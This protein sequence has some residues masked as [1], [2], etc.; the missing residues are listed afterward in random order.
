MEGYAKAATIFKPLGGAMAGRFT[1]AVLVDP[2]LGAGGGKDEGGLHIPSADDHKSKR[3]EEEKKKGPEGE[4]EMRA[5]ESPKEHAARMGMYGMLTREV[6]VWVPAKLLC[7]R[8]GVKD[9]NPAPTEPEPGPPAQTQGF[10][11][12]QASSTDFSEEPGVAAAAAD[13]TTMTGTSRK[14]G[15]RDLANIGLG[16]DDDQGRDI[17]TYSRPAM[18]IFKAIF[19]SDDESGD[20]GGDGGE[21]A[22]ELDREAVPERAKP[23]G[24]AIPPEGKKGEKE[25]EKEK[26]QEKEKEEEK[27]DMATFRPVFVP[28]SERSEPSKKEKEKKDKKKSGKSKGKTLVSFELDEEGGGGLAIKPSKEERPKKKKKKRRDNSGAVGGEEGDDDGMWVEKPPPEVVKSLPPPSLQADA[29]GDG[30][31]TETDM[32]PPRGRK[33]AIDFM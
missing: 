28:R 12:P 20:E 25:P 26:K 3:H 31:T 7:K 9:P 13:T 6:K 2:K 8:F 5:D 11:Q 29:G 4:M 14:N 19:A 22:L 10:G 32:G 18:D 24:E 15:P 21:E 30:D 27:L 1:S 17:L 16:E 23:L 33:R